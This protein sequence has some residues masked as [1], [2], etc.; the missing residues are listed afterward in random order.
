[1]PMSPQSLTAA[2]LRVLGV[3]LLFAVLPLVSTPEALDIREPI[4]RVTIAGAL[5]AA[6]GLWWVERDDPRLPRPVWWAMGAVALAAWAA[7]WA[8]T[9]SWSSVVG[10]YPRDEG[11]VMILAYLAALPAGAVLLAR[12]LGRQA[13]VWAATASGWV[14]V[15][16]GVRDATG[17]QVHRVV[18]S[19]GNASTVGV[20]GLMLC[21]WLGWVAWRERSWLALAGAASGAGL[22]VLGAS[23]GAMVGLGV[24]AL[25]SL[26][27]VARTEGVRR[28]VAPAAVMVAGVVTVLVLPMT[29]DRIFLA[30]EGAGTNIT[31]RLMMWRHT[32]GV[33][34]DDLLFGIGP[35]RWVSSVDGG[36]GPAW[37]E[38]AGA[39]VKLDGVHNVVLQTTAALGLVGLMAVVMLSLAV[40]WALLR[41]V[42][43]PWTSE[44]RSAQASWPAAALVV[45]VGMACALMFAYTE[46]VFVVPGAALVGGGLA[47]AGRV[48]DEQHQRPHDGVGSPWADAE[49]GQESGQAIDWSRPDQGIGAVLAHAVSPQGRG[50][51]LTH[52]HRVLL[53]GVA[54][55][56]SVG[57]L[58]ASTQ[59]WT[60]YTEARL[61]VAGPPSVTRQHLLAVQE[62]AP[63][64]PNP[65]VRAA[66]VVTNLTA[67]RTVWNPAYGHRS[68]TH[69]HV[70]AQE[71]PRIG[72]DQ[73]CLAW[74][75]RAATQVGDPV[76]GQVLA[77]RAV[78]MGP[79][80]HAS[81]LAEHDAYLAAG[82]PDLAV[83]AAQRHAQRNPELYTAWRM[84]A[85]AQ[86][87]AGDLASAQVSQARADQLMWELQGL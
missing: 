53:A 61:A 35:S 62:A 43:W 64:D 56:A 80:D 52:G 18:T 36:Y 26:V 63:F 1:M 42:L 49:A 16:M 82:R 40:G 29:R 5:V 48:Q 66:G 83:A 2:V 47:V 22:V 10:R 4:R 79:D 77:Q 19:L 71:C 21:A 58:V 67:G 27:L 50:R 81:R 45:G 65:A 70:L 3:V 14:M 7:T 51:R 34:R 59:Q 86:K 33:I 15:W 55:V 8:S 78:A 30:E 72:P 76:F 32:A 28:I 12:R 39:G 46:P 20:W 13:A 69:L 37:Q 57:A 23:R 87:A 38:Q 11:L 31:V 75:S 24:G 73:Q 41:V 60:A 84:L 54:T 74:Q 44:V 9:N 25:L 85:R 68:D 17:G 6:T